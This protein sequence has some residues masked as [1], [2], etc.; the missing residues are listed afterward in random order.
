MAGEQRTVQKHE[1]IPEDYFRELRREEIAA[2]GVPLELDVGCGDGSFLLA[3]AKAHPERAFLGL[4]RLLGRVRKVCRGAERQ[5]LENLQ[6]LRLES[7][8]AMEYLIPAGSASRVH[9]LFPDP[10]PKKK[11]QERRALRSATAPYFARVLEADGEFLFKTDDPPYF[12]EGIEC[13]RESGL[14]R[15]EAWPEDAFFYPSTD[16]E[17]QWLAEGKRIQRARFIKC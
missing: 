6:V 8:Y 11:H 7:L 9:L 1:F 15:E 13:L 3:M 5:H 4:E 16:F 12:E 14:F 2:P 17:R 10:W